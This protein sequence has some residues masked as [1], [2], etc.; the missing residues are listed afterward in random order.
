MLSIGE[1]VIDVPEHKV[2]RS[3]EQIRKLNEVTYT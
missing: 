2:S 3:D 1:V